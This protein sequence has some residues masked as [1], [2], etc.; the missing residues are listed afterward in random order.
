VQDNVNIDT[1]TKRL[2]EAF[3]TRTVNYFFNHKIRSLGVLAMKECGC[4]PDFIGDFDF[5]KY[6]GFHKRPL[7]CIY[8]TTKYY[9][10]LQVG[11]KKNHA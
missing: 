9:D 11:V 8:I 5:G 6:L 1:G 4:N 3:A 2:V 7:R 10:E